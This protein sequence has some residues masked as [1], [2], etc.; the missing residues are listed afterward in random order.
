MMVEEE[1]DI[2]RF[3]RNIMNKYLNTTSQVDPWECYLVAITE[4]VNSLRPS[5]AYMRQKTNHHWFR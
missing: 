1:N 3:L 2:S 4:I 5:D